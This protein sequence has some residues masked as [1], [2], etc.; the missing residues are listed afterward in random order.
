VDP[1]GLH[2]SLSELK[3]K[4]CDDDDDAAAAVTVNML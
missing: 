3:K 4:D 2:P 1:A